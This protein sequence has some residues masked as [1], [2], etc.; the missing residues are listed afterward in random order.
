MTGEVLQPKALVLPAM[1][2]AVRD[3]LVN[4]D[5]GT[6]IVNTTTNKINYYNG[7]AWEAVTSA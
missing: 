2:E 1:T 5:K 4:V 6:V 7:S 3:T